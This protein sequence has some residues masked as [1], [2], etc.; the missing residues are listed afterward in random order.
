MATPD[1][2]RVGKTKNM[3]IFLRHRAFKYMLVSLFDIFMQYRH[4]EKLKVVP[5]WG[6]RFVKPTTFAVLWV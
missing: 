4:Q 5:Y 1:P 2:G 6:Q 3:R